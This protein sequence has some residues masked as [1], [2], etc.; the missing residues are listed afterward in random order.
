MLI[1]G[2]LAA[3]ALV[4]YLHEAG[5]H[6]GYYT[7][8]LMLVAISLSFG[9]AVTPW[10]ASFT[11]TVEARNPALTATGLAI[12]GWPQRVVAFASFLLIPV[13]IT[14]VTPLVN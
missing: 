8:A 3:V 6:L 5:H 12:W 11:E 14:S 7:V 10:L 13:V 9:I 2:T 1:G 4:V